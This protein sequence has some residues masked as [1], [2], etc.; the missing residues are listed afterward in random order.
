MRIL[1]IGC[2]NKLVPAGEGDIVVNHD[3]V[4]HRPEIDV[5]W[6][7]NDL[8]WPW[9]DNSFDSIVACA[10][11]EHLRITLIES[12]GECW[13]ILAPG[14]RVRVKVPWWRADAAYQDCTHYWV[15]STGVFDQ[16]DPTTKRGLQYQFYEGWRPW[17]IVKSAHLNPEHTS[18]ICTLEV[19]KPWPEV[20][21]AGGEGR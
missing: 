17:R 13:R 10:V 6:D 11:L 15:F 14:G 21:P 2:G 8:R 16:F 12:L 18:V 4:K 20:G 9:P 7:L 5:V 3:R 1:N 19:R